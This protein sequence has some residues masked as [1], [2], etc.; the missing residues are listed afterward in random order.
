[1]TRITINDRRNVLIRTFEVGNRNTFTI[2]RNTREKN[3]GYFNACGEGK[4]AVPLSGRK[5]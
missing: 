3:T 1:M 5:K 4:P 2:F